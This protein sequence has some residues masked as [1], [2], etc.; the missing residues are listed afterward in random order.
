MPASAMETGRSC[1]PQESARIDHR[2]DE[3]DDG[4]RVE[5]LERR[6]H[7]ALHDLFFRDAHGH[8][9][10]RA[11][12]WKMNDTPTPGPA[13]GHVR[14]LYTMEKLFIIRA[15]SNQ[16]PIGAAK[17]AK[18]HCTSQSYNS[19]IASLQ[20]PVVPAIVSI[21][22]PACFIFSA[23]SR[24]FFSRPFSIPCSIPCSMPCSRP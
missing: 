18:P 16:Q 22:I 5:N 10:L 24:A 3:D 13:P 2:G 8:L 11:V 7:R 20:R 14:V 1:F 23:I 15:Y 6:L 12:V 4:S 19:S 21:S 9:V 17:T